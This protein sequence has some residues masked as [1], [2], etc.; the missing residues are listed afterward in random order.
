MITLFTPGK[1]KTLPR[2]GV[3]L[4]NMSTVG[5]K[6]LKRRMNPYPSSR[7]PKMTHPIITTTSPPKK[8]SDPFKFRGLVKKRMVGYGPM[9][10]DTPDRNSSCM[11]ST[12]VPCFETRPRSFAYA[13]QAKVL[14]FP[15][16]M[17]PRS[18]KNNTPTKVKKH[19]AAV[20][21][22]PISARRHQRVPRPNILRSATSSFETLRLS[23]LPVPHSC[24]RSARRPSGR[25]APS[26]PLDP[27]KPISR[28]WVQGLP[29]P[30][31]W[32]RNGCPI[33]PNKMRR[34]QDV[35]DRQCLCALEMG[36][37]VA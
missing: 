17:R 20:S 10:I 21:P 2:Y 30:V 36:R 31:H 24:C 11:R 32:E 4:R 23:F 25:G 3:L 19:P 33:R 37:N 27:L 9:V 35:Q 7:S 13:R 28:M 1:S 22:M 16:E 6:P 5:R 12:S 8:Q 14:T 15:I 34:S 26:F 18:R 29:S